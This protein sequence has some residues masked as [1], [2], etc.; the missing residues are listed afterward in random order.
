MYALSNAIEC[1]EKNISDTI[2]Q[3]ITF[4]T[5]MRN[6]TLSDIRNHIVFL[7][8]KEFKTV[9]ATKPYYR[10]NCTDAIFLACDRKT[11]LNASQTK[12]LGIL[13]ETVYYIHHIQ[14]IKNNTLNG[15]ETTF[16]EHIN[17]IPLIQS[18]RYAYELL[19]FALCT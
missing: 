13:L 6:I 7:N 8:W 19:K 9:I 3:S 2:L 17:S 11:S 1:N 14:K 12:E 5:W 15:S 10:S 16:H 18:V 4:D